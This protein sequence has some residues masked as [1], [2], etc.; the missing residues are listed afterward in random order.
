MAWWRG[1]R[2]LAMGISVAAA[3]PLEP[4]VNEALLRA[5]PDRPWQ[6]RLL[7]R[8]LARL[9]ELAN[10]GGGGS[11]PS[12]DDDVNHL[13][14]LAEEA[15]VIELVN[16]MLA[17]AMDLRASDVHIEPEEAQFHAHAH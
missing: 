16:N 13:R 12:W 7:Q 11:D 8:L 2:P 3:D 17:Q 1:N 10:A 5:F 15:P 14:E 4:V 9:L 6:W